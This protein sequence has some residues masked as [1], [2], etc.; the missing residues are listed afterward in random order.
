MPICNR[1]TFTPV[2]PTYFIL[3]AWRYFARSFELL[4]EP[5][6]VHVQSGPKRLCKFWIF[7]DGSVQL[8][9]SKGMSKR[10]LSAVEAV[11][12]A[13]IQVIKDACESYCYQNAI[14]VN[15]KTKRATW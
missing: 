1:S 12:Q 3:A 7:S 11:I 15:Y 4:Y 6:H 2:T 14:A 8:A 9:N 13:E 5:C 10:E